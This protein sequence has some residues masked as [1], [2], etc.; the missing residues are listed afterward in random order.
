MPPRDDPSDPKNEIS[1]DVVNQLL[2]S[3]RLLIVEYKES[4]DITCHACGLETL[5]ANPPDKIT[6]EVPVRLPCNHIYGLACLVRWALNRIDKGKDATCPSCRAVYWYARGGLEP[7]P[8]RPVRRPRAV[9]RSAIL[10]AAATLHDGAAGLSRAPDGLVNGA[11]GLEMAR[12][13]VSQVLRQVQ[14]IAPDAPTGTV[15]AQDATLGNVNIDS[16][17]DGMYDSD[18]DRIVPEPVERSY[19]PRTIR[20]RDDIDSDIHRTQGEAATMEVDAIDAQGAASDD[21]DTDVGDEEVLDDAAPLTA[22]VG[23]ILPDIRRRGLSDL[24][25]SIH[26]DTDGSSANLTPLPTE[27]EH[28]SD[29]I[30]RYIHTTRVVEDG[31]SYIYGIMPPG[32]T[33]PSYFHVRDGV[34]TEIRNITRL[35]GGPPDHD[36]VP[37]V[38][39][40]SSRSFRRHGD[41]RN[42]PYYRALCAIH[43]APVPAEYARAYLDPNHRMPY[44]L[45]TTTASISPEALNEFIADAQAQLA[46]LGSRDRRWT[47]EHAEREWIQTAEFLWD[48]FLDHITSDGVFNDI[49]PQQVNEHGFNMVLRAQVVEIILS[50]ENVRW[51]YEAN[52][53]GRSGIPALSHLPWFG[54]TYAALLLHLQL[55]RE[56]AHHWRGEPEGGF[57]RVFRNDRMN[58]FRGRMRT[59]WANVRREMMRVNRLGWEVVHDL[60]VEMDMEQ[61]L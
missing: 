46:R 30:G 16:D 42:T 25:P 56:V 33:A 14:Q 4:D 37:P 35:A 41:D 45:A 3:G 51:F 17:N 55:D 1:A 21:A 19:T 18:G 57:D 50:F 59:H 61:G 10:R 28:F 20:H 44:P 13:E 40:G 39:P 6:A 38:R 22:S 58:M 53:E 12:V 27:R 32:Y 24:G 5:T 31:V 9:N 11:A 26:P 8:P 48:R 7:A 29:I 2:L 43:D 52:T 49:V 23:P 47:L 36:A 34:T 15:S 54:P 60:D